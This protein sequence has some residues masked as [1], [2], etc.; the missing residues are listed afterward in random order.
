MKNLHIVRRTVLSAAAA[1]ALVFP[2]LGSASVLELA[3]HYQEH[4]DGLVV[5][6]GFAYAAPL[7]RLLGIDPRALGFEEEAG[8]RNIDKITKFQKPTLIIHAECTLRYRAVSGSVDVLSVPM[9]TSIRDCLEAIK[10]C[11]NNKKLQPNR[12]SQT[13]SLHGF[14]GVLAR[15][16]LNLPR[17]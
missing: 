6:S 7:L 5:E 2:L 12:A 3:A 15:I 16:I 14:M 1:A 4:L 13:A 11:N 17:A 10:K 9:Y 8:F